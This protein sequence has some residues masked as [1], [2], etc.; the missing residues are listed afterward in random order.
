MKY[1]TFTLEIQ[2][3]RMLKLPADVCD[4]LRIEAGDRVE[5]SIKRIKSG[6]LDLIL[7]ENPLNQLLGL[8]KATAA[9]GDKTE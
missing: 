9:D 1:A 8:N 6:R 4:K 2:D 3:G 7:S 5:I